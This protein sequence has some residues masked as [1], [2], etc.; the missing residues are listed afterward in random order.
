MYRR[1]LAREHPFRHVNAGEDYAFVVAAALGGASCLAYADAS[2]DSTV[3]HVSHQSNLS[4]CQPQHLLRSAAHG[5]LTV[6]EDAAGFGEHFGADGHHVRPMLLAS[7][8]LLHEEHT[9]AAAA[10]QRANGGWWE[11]AHDAGCKLAPAL[12]ARLPAPWAL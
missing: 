5:P 3:V 8:S 4:L 10:A 2:P 1:A 11:P 12:F 6:E 9:R 7:A